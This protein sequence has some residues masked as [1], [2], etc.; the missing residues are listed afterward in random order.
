METW[1]LKCAFGNNRRMESLISW[2]Y[3]L[4]QVTENISSVIN[5]LECGDHLVF[6]LETEAETCPQ[7][8]GTKESQAS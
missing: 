7:S 4:K 2:D 6:M 3:V 8:D 1:A 5:Y